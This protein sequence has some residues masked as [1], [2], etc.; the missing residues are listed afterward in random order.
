[1]T[2]IEAQQ[3]MKALG[4][5]LFQTA[6]AAI[7][8]GITREHASKLLARLVSAGV[9][10]SVARGLWGFVGAVDS[11]LVPEALTAPAPA[12]ISLYSALFYHEMI[13]QIPETVYAISLARTRKYQ[14]P[15]GSVSIHHI[16]ESF[17]FGFEVVGDWSV[18]MAT[19][20]KALLDTLY[21]YPARSGW[22]KRLP[23]LSLA[24]SF[25]VQNAFAMT[26]KIPSLRTRTMVQ[27]KLEK[28]LKKT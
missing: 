21:L 9:L 5:P 24:S 16:H 6:D 2:L 4:V 28:I 23:E 13:S 19:P 10:L 14:T 7:C 1:M 27:K 3:K 22:F 26:K 15:V 12:Y 17:F 25:N 8:L 11:L 18:K 20:E